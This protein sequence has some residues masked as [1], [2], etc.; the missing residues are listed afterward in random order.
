MT[1]HLWLYLRRA[2]N[3][4]KKSFESHS[5]CGERQTFRRKDLNP[6]LPAERGNLSKK[7][8]ESHSTCGE[9]QPF[10]RK[11]LNPTLPAERGGF[12]PPKRFRRLH[13]FQACL[14][15]HSS[16]SPWRFRGAKVIFLFRIR[17]IPLIIYIYFRIKN[18]H[19][20]GITP[21]ANRFSSQN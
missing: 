14:F 12:E 16:I 3:L 9:R 18:R 11:A 4:S 2:T 7:R 8:F 19:G 6:T 20:N 17:A 10:R 21:T 1:Y 15:S 13:A 5:T